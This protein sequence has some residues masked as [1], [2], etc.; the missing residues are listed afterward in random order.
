MIVSRFS[1]TIRSTMHSPISWLGGKSRLVNTILP[2]IPEHHCYVEPFAGA[3]W[4]LFAKE[5]SKVE[6]LND[7]NRDLVTMYRTIRHHPDEFMRLVRYLLTSREEFETFRKTDPTTLTDV[8]RAV[9][10]YYLVK[11]SY[12]SKLDFG[13]WSCGPRTKSSFNIFRIEQ[14]ISDAHVRL[15]RTYI[16]N[17]PYQKIVQTYDRPETFYYLD[18]P[19]WGCEDYYGE[20]IFKR[21]DFEVIRDILKGLQGRFIMSLNDT[22]EVRA[23]FKDFDIRQV[24]T[25][26][27]VGNTRKGVNEVL[28]LNI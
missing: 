3:A 20:G 2:L 5:P 10:F 24:K 27:F 11:N 17:R 25:Q 12:G 1:S 7:I 23:M 9:R 18:P 21:E 28:I 8:Q 22:K 6:V 4:L 26:Y 13:S 14:E 16:E 19:Y 15:A